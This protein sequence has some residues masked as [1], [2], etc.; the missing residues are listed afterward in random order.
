MGRE[1]GRVKK[2]LNA[3]TKN[4]GL[5]NKICCIGNISML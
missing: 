2:K 3:F 1:E 5:A 4:P